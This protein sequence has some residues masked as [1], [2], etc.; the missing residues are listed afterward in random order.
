MKYPSLD[1]VVVVLFFFGGGGEGGDQTFFSGDHFAIEGCA[2]LKK[3]TKSPVVY[4]K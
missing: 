3:L 2:F 4:S 1:F